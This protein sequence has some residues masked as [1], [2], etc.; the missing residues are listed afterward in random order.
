MTI[1]RLRSLFV[2]TG[3][4]ITVLAS[5]PLEAQQDDATRYLVSIAFAGAA[6][7]S[8]QLYRQEPLCTNT[9]LTGDQ[10]QP[11][12]GCEGRLQVKDFFGVA[13]GVC[14]LASVWELAR[15][16][17]LLQF[18]P[19]ALLTIAPHA[20]PSLRPPNLTY[21]APRHEVRALLIHAAF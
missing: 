15:A 12:N 17:H 4:V 8:Y 9:Y 2:L 13:A 20:T 19:G 16:V 18:R 3:S 5:K 6:V 1:M 21:N 7:G 14:A 10:A 11:T